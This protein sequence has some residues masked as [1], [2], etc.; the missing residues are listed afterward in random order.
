VKHQIGPIKNPYPDLCRQHL[1][2]AASSV[3]KKIR[4]PRCSKPFKTAKAVLK[5]QDAF[6]PQ[7]LGSSFNEEDDDIDKIIWGNIDEDISRQGFERMPQSLRDEIDH[8]V[9]E[10]LDDLA[11][12]ELVESRKWELRKWNMTWRILFPCY[13]LPS[14]PCKYRSS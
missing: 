6:P 10:A 4:C 5:H 2:N 11:T 1:G 9:V 3:H 12:N 14:S 7:C 8:W 13:D